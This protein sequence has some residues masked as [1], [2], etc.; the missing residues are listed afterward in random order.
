VASEDFLGSHVLRLPAST[1]A[2]G[3]GKHA[4]G[5]KDGRGKA[6]QYNTVNGKTV[7]IKETFIYSNR[8]AEQHAPFTCLLRSGSL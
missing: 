5:A 2:D 1:V 4:A 8:G 6:K 3:G 7:I